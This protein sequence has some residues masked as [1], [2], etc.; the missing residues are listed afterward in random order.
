[1]SQLGNVPEIQ[2]VKRK[3]EDLKGRGLIKAWEIPYEEVLTRLTAAIFFLT[4]AE[5]SDPEQIW[6]E[7]DSNEMLQYR[8]NEE[9]QLS[10]LDWRMEFNKGF[11]V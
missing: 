1:M 9:K 5:G 3:M 7:F 8:M 10:Q 6:K 2:T 4:P 11:T